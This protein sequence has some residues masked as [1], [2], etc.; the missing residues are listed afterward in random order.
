M[1]LQLRCSRCA[2]P[3]LTGEVSTWMVPLWLCTELGL[4]LTSAEVL[5]AGSRQGKGDKLSFIA[6]FK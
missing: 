4:S 2:E 5:R 3:P 1:G 6:W